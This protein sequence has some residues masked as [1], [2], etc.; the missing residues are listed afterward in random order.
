MGEVCKKFPAVCKNVKEVKDSAAPHRFDYLVKLSFCL[1][2]RRKRRLIQSF[3][4]IRRDDEN[5]GDVFFH[6]L[7]A[8]SRKQRLVF[9]NC[10]R[11]SMK[12]CSIYQ[13]FVV[14]ALVNS[15]VLLFISSKAIEV[16]YFFTEHLIVCYILGSF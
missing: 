13:A 11:I 1:I 6:Q 2:H 14:F 16:R 3:Q 4:I 7:V 9:R 12:L 10:L 5:G 8:K 15:P